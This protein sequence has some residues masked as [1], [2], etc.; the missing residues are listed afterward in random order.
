MVKEDL[1]RVGYLYTLNKLLIIFL[2]WLTRE[3][4]SPFLPGNYEG[5]HPNVILDSLIHWDAGW[6]L[7]IAGQGYD[8]DSAPFFPAFP[9]LIRALT[10][11]TG[12]GVASGFIISNTAFFTACFLFYRMVRE[13]YGEEIAVTAVF[14]MLF[15]PTAIFFTS[16]YSESPFLAFTLGAFYFA[17]KKK[18]L[19]AAFLGACAAL[20]RN[21]GV[22]LFLALVY[23]SYKE[24]GYKLNLKQASQLLLIPLSL[25]VFMWVLRVSTGDPLGFVHSLNRE[26][27]GYRHLAY[28]GAGQI[29]N[30]SLFLKNSEF[31]SL[32]ESGMAILFLFLVLRSFKY[33]E[34]RSFLIF[35][36]FGFLIPFSSVVDNLPLGM[37][38]YVIVLFPGYIT[39]ARILHKHRLVN[40]YSIISVFVFSV[41]SVIFVTGRWIS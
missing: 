7:R 13:D 32:F 28:P 30:L 17:R 2:I 29:L 9:F 14:A 27:W 41:I 38:R 21:I 11:V 26:Y 25:T 37:P 24:N 36:V 31:Y 20:T 10:F 18:W 19:A 8:F 40:V 23:E 6:F 4:L 39:L 33:V 1:K 12:D 35:L 34:N 15:F 3:V 16:I 5:M 22:V